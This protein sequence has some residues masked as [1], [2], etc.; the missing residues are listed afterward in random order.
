M[1]ANRTLL[2]LVLLC[3]VC[4]LAPA[5]ISDTRELP[6]DYVS[7]RCSM[8]PDGDWGE[9]CVQH[10]KAYFF[11]GS[12]KARRNAD[13]K[14]FQCVRARG[15]LNHRFISDVMWLGVRVGGIA[16]L[17]T[18]FRWGFGKDWRSDPTGQ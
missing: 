10:D 11:G 4:S 17:P 16:F 9:C 12:E 14:L 6:S 5:Q 1:N 3:Y 7:D 2:L 18:S 13:K 8:F 15:G